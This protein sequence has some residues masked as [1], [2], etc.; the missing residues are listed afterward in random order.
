V[1]FGWSGADPV[2]DADTADYE[3]G[4]EMV[5]NVDITI[6]H[7]RIFGT[8]NAVDQPS[9]QGKIW[10]TTTGTVL[11]TATMP[12]TLL[13]GWNSYALATPLERL[14][15]ERWLVSYATGGRYGEIVGALNADITS[16]DGAVTFLSNANATAGNGRINNTPGSYPT[17]A[18]AGVFWGTDVT[19]TLG[20]GNTAPVITGLGLSTSGLTVTATITATDAETLAGAT[21]LIDWGDGSTTA[22]ATG[23]HTYASSGPKAVLGS[24]TDSAGLSDHAA[25]AVVLA[26]PPVSTADV[27]AIINALLS[28]ALS[29]GVFEHVN[30]H[31][32]KAAPMDGLHGSLWVDEIAPA[33][34]RSGT[35]ATSV[36]LAFNF[37]VQT[38]MMA[39]PQDDID[40]A[41]LVAVMLL[42]RAYSGDFELGGQAAFID[43]LGAHGAPLAAKAGYLNQ[44]NRLYRVMVLA[45]PIILNDVFDQAP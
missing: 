10:N 40:P 43:L 42:M 24:V 20:V 14:A 6:T 22:A 32:P 28:H 26:D 8:P 35:S 9:R 18:T 45:I 29:L 3:L 2:Q 38:S 5:A 7:V 39:E 27:L 16:N 17:I 31:E 41:I 36:R 23:Q 13:A 21:Y 25:A 44:D 11:A 1:A 19:Y 30:G 15:G 12:D 33:Q 34:R 4:V 37:R